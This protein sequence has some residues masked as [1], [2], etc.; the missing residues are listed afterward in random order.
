MCEKQT[1]KTTG[2]INAFQ[3]NTWH[4]RVKG[5]LLSE[6]NVFKD[7]ITRWSVKL[8][9]EAYILTQDKRHFTLDER[10]FT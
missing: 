3:C 6:Q 4:Y 2:K 9:S 7:F 1:T 8:L 10:H 5:G